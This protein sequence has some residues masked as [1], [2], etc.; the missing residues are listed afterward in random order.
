MFSVVLRN[1]SERGVLR[2]GVDIEGMA[3]ALLQLA[4]GMLI[5]GATLQRPDE[6]VR[7]FRAQVALIDGRTDMRAKL[8]TANNSRR[9][10]PRGAS[11]DS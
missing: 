7:A 6:L 1:S 2:A 8:R 4:I 3:G 10:G 5:R 9:S 11:L